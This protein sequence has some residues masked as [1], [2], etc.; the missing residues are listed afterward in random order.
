MKQ[1]AADGLEGLRRVRGLSREAL[2]ARAGGISA[3]TIWRIE[4]GICRPHRSTIAALACAL[5]C[6]VHDLDSKDRS[7]PAEGPGSKTQMTD[8]GGQGAV[9]A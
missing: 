7:S 9:A 8:S 3:A 6:E 5:G 4:R 2:G 1:E